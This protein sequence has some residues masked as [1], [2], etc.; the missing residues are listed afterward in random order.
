M[1]HDLT[2]L[3]EKRQRGNMVQI[4]E[5]FDGFDIMEKDNIFNIIRREVTISQIQNSQRQHSCH[6]VLKT[7]TG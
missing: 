2:T 5:I 3:S 6:S 1:A 4:F 7:L